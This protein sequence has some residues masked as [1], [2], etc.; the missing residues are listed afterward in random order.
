MIKLII[1][2]VLG[3]A[4]GIGGGTAASV[5]KARKAFAT[6]EAG[7]A[8]AV[9]DSIAKG[10]ERPGDD[11]AS[12]EH[13]APAADSAKTD[14]ATAPHMASGV[15][16]TSEKGA[17]AATTARANAGKAT[18]RDSPAPTSTRPSTTSKA[19]ETV[20]AGGATDRPRLAALPPK[21]AEAV[22]GATQSEKVAKIFA[23]MPA[24]DAAKVLEQLDDPEVQSILNGLSAKQA[25]GI[26]QYL[27]PARAAS[28]SKLVLRGGHE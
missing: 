16:A 24:K 4:V 25:A 8:K 19:V 13:G 9:A 12:T 6:F 20:V 14:S 18:R 7:K 17:H 2:L 5:M 23:A 11:V 10:T 3:V 1:F 26:L 27:P 28:I 15:P 21:P 22:I